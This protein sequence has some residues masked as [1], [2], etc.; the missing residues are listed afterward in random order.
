MLIH[1]RQTIAG[2]P[3]SCSVLELYGSHQMAAVAVSAES[4]AVAEAGQREG[5]GSDAPYCLSLPAS[6]VLAE[7]TFA[8]LRQEGAQGDLIE[9]TRLR[10]AVGLLVPTQGRFSLRAKRAIRDAGVK[11]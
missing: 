2:L 4:A 9:S 8:L 11:A 5:Y 6:A 10:Q 1:V 3:A 7:H